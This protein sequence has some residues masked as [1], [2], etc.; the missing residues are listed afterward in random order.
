MKIR[1]GFVSNSSSSS[2]IVSMNKGEDYKATIT[3]EVDL[4]EMGSKIENIEQLLEYSKENWYYNGEMDDY[5]KERYDKMKS[6]IEA[7]KIVIVGSFCDDSGD[8][9]ESLLCYEGLEGHVDES[10][11][12]IIHS[13][14]GY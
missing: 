9:K 4:A 3:F 11:V 12:C 10:K 14:G 7:G 2:F 13:D 6:M 5:D 8:P 1:N